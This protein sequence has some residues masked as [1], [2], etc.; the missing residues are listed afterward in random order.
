MGGEFVPLQAL[1][2]EILGGSW[3]NLASVNEHVPDIERLTLVAKESLSSIWH[4][5]PFNRIP[6]LFLIHLEFQAIKMLNHFPVKGGYM[7][8]WSPQKLWQA[9]VFTTRKILDYILHSISKY[10]RKKLIIPITNSVP[11][12]SFVWDQAVICKLDSS[13]WAWVQLKIFLEYLGIWSLC[14]I[15]LFTDSTF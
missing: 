3:F 14:L 11:K 10:L 1:I 4:R 13:L 6:K 2:H 8:R 15:Q 12:V 7:T 5:L 9:I